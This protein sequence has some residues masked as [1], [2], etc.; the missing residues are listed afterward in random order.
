VWAGIN[1]RKLS[2]A[3]TEKAGSLAAMEEEGRSG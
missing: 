2:I 1:K 3:F